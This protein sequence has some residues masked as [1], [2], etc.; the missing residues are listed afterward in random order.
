VNIPGGATIPSALTPASLQEFH[1]KITSAIGNIV[2]TKLPQCIAWKYADQY[3]LPSSVDV[4]AFCSSPDSCIPL[5]SMFELAGYDT[6]A[7]TSL[8]S[9]AQAQGSHRYLQI[10]EKTAHAATQHLRRV[11]PDYKTVQI[12][13]ESNGPTLAPVIV[14]ETVRLDMANR[15]DGFKRFASFLLQISAKVKTD[16]LVDSLILIDEPEIALHPSGAKSLMRELIE[17][18]H[19]NYVVYSTHSIFMIDK[20][21]IDRHLVVEKKK[22]VTTTWRAEKSRI[23]D[24]EVLYGA[25]GY[26]LFESLKKKNVIF[27]GWRDKE[28][29]R[30][31][32]TSAS[33]ANKAKKAALASIGM[34]FAEGVKDVRNVAKI[35]Q[36]ADRPCLIVSD[37]DNPALQ[38][39]KLYEVPGA[40]GTWVTLQDIFPN[41]ALT[42]I[43]DLIE[44]PALIK[45]ANKLRPMVEGLAELDA[46]FFQAN[47]PSLG[48]LKR[49]LQSAGLQGQAQEEAMNNLKRLLFEDLKRSELS[50]GADA[51]VDYVLAFN[52]SDSKSQEQEIISG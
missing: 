16:Q 8:I 21:N 18:G 3:L 49:W 33:K 25:I 39:K 52:F 37:A 19:K 22:E 42:T 34:T 17:I 1:S 5:K 12:R 31:V 4:A 7:L 32:A 40:W 28:V 20:E 50:A 35:L 13:L 41:L 24:E 38:Q 43:E 30:V 2:T 51:L 27:E 14:D 47:E 48:G 6:T 15:S 9:N 26:S 11:W 36:L 46:N 44:R 45:R 10:L 23:Q 29:F